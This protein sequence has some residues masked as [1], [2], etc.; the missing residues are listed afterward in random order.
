[1][2]YCGRMKREREREIHREKERGTDLVEERKIE[3]EK[4]A[5]ER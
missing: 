5:R 4:R 1:M 2:W 3:R